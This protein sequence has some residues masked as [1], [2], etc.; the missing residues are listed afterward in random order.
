MHS[1]IH[2]HC[3][4][5]FCDKFFEISEIQN[6]I[7]ACNRKGYYKHTNS[8]G[9]ARSNVVIDR[10]GDIFEKID[11]MCVEKKEN[12]VDVLFTKL[13]QNLKHEQN[14]LCIDVDNIFKEYLKGET[15]SISEFESS[16]VLKSVALKSQCPH[17]YFITPCIL[18]T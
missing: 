15:R 18:S 13:I 8:L 7:V 9:E 12:S 10:V 16:D 14:N 4:N 3:S 2:I 11:A 6:H 17:S 5:S 1:S